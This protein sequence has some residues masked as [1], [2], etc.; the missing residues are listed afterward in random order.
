MEVTPPFGI[1][2]SLLPS[3]HLHTTTTPC[4]PP[5]VLLSYFLPRVGTGRDHTVSWKWGEGMVWL[6]RSFRSP[7]AGPLRTPYPRLHPQRGTLYAPWMLM[8]ELVPAHGCCSEA[9]LVTRLAG[10]SALSN[11]L[12]LPCHLGPT[13]GFGGSVWGATS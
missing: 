1:P 3:P 5:S 12:C 7:W 8:G 2:S 13:S 4:H 11:C 10:L 9:E 6:G